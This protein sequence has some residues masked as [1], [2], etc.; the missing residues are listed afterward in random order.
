MSETLFGA[1]AAGAVVLAGLD[2]LL[3]LGLIV[4]RARPQWEA[5]AAGRAAERAFE[6][7]HP[8]PAG[9]RA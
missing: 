2:A 5:D 3:V 4:T 8:R 1:L 7:R 6:L 9:P